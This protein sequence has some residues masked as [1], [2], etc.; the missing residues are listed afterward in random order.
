MSGQTPAL[1]G[2]AVDTELIDVG[3]VQGGVE[4]CGSVLQDVIRAALEMLE[5]GE[6]SHAFL[7]P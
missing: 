7:P 1:P 4:A 5:K 2:E 6:N 3:A